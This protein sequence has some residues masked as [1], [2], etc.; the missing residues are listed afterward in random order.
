MAKYKLKDEF[1]GVIVSRQVP[2]LG[3]V[4][5]DPT[6]VEPHKFENYVRL[7]FEYMFELVIEEVIEWVGEKIE[8]WIEDKEDKK[9]NIKDLPKFDE[10]PD[11]SST[12]LLSH[13]VETPIPTPKIKRPIKKK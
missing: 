10:K 11:V 6:K 13:P 8:S 4:V 2:G 9:V 5:F 7:G 1:E 3:N 12:P